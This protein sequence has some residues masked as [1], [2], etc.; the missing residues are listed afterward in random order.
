MNRGERTE[1]PPVGW[2]R[3]QPEH[4][5]VMLLGT[6]HMDNPGLDVAQIDIDDVLA[7]E[8]QEEIQSVI[9]ALAEWNPDRVTVERPYNRGE[10]VNSLYEEYR[11][12]KKS[13]C[14]EETIEPPHPARNE[15]T[16]E[17]RSEV[18]QLGFRLAD[19]L[20]H[21]QVYPIDYPLDIANEEYEHLA[22][23]GFEPDEKVSFDQIDVDDVERRITE[24]I[25]TSTISEYLVWENQE[26]QLSREYEFLFGE[27]LRWGD[28]DNFGGP[29]LIA[30]WYDRNLRMMHNLWR[31][32]ETGDKR[33]ILV[34]GSS[35][36][37]V[38][39]DLLENTPMFCPVSPLPYLQNAV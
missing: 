16:T 34:V 6:Y 9:R 24:Q 8:R 13:Y 18:I 26:A 23:R 7:P 2:P 11:S 29:K 31:T 21:E 33:L 39:R 36:V 22:D 27:Y 1:E 4:V 32:I 15:L 35:H 25:A 38:L 30:K 10:N 17:C 12:G 3:C 14:T 5:R 28:G 37:K 20:D 19:R